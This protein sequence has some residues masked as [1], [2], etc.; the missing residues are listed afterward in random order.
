MQDFRKL[1]V[2]QRAH[3]LTLDVYRATDALPAA[4]RYGLMSQMRSAAVSIAS[5]IA[6][7]CGRSSDADFARFLHNAV[8]SANE[9]E[10][11]IIIARDLGYL[12]PDVAERLSGLRSEVKRMLVAL[13]TKSASGRRRS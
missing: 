5:N 10:C 7:G 13:I 8:G 12:T 11:Q 9:L 1:T 6:E 2:W 4:E 3:A